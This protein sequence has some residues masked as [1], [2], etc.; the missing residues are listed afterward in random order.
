MEIVYDSIKQFIERS[1]YINIRI[2]LVFT[3]KSTQNKHFVNFMSTYN[4]TVTTSSSIL[5]LIEIIYVSIHQ[6]TIK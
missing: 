2:Y 4:P 3:N 5:R 6:Y 1:N